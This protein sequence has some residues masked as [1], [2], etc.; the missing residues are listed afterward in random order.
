MA[1]SAGKTTWNLLAV[2]GVIEHQVYELATP[3]GDGLI[4]AYCLVVRGRSASAKR[5]SSALAGVDTDRVY[6]RA[7]EDPSV[8]RPVSADSLITF[9][10]SSEAASEM[11]IS[12]LILARV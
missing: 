4:P 6:N 9:I 11:T 12:N 1:G 7:D 5:I 3:H 2:P 10:A 8:A